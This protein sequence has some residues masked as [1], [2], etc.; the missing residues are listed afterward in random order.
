MRTTSFEQAQEWAL[1]LFGDPNVAQFWIPPQNFLQ[2]VRND[3]SISFTRS[4]EGLYGLA[5]GVDPIIPTE[6][7]RFSVFRTVPKL[8]TESCTVKGQWAAYARSTEPGPSTLDIRALSDDEFIKEFLET[9][10]P[11]SSVFPGNP[12]VR[13]WVGIWSD[14][15]VAGIAAITQWESGECMVSSVAT[16]TAFRGQGYAKKL[17]AGVV[18]RAFTL[19][20]SRL[21]LAVMSK[22]RPA[23][24]VYEAVGFKEMGDFRYFERD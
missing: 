20:Y 22:N 11:E 19:G 16:A 7:N 2:A 14:E 1:D 23:R 9:H 12:E 10:A 13:E 24:A 5:L 15:E 18:G 6:W 8:L 4:D 21:G 3:D 17:M